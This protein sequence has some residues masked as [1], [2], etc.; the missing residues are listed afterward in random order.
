M[1]KFLISLSVISIAL[2]P[3]LG[4]AADLR[5]KDEVSLAKAEVINEDAYI[6]GGNVTLANDIK[7]DLVVAG[8]NI[9]ISGVVENDLLAAGGNLNI[10]GTIRDDARI[11]GGTVIVSGNVG[12]DI[13]VAGGQIQILPGSTIGGDL[14]VAGG[15]VTIDGTVNG[16][17]Q[18]RGGQLIINDAVAGNVDA[19]ID[20]LK[21]GSHSLINGDLFYRSLE[22]GEIAQGA[23]INGTTKF[24]KFEKLPPQSA[25]NLKAILAS[26]L[27]AKFLVLAG[28]LIFLILLFG[29]TSRAITRQ[30]IASFWKEA[31]RGFVLLVVTPV[32]AIF[33]FV[34]IVGVPLGGLMLL[35]YFASL[36]IAYLFSALILGSMLYKLVW[37]KSEYEANWKTALLGSAVITIVG[38]IPFIGGFVKFIFLLVALGALVKFEY[39][40]RWLNR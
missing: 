40:R 19:K 32:A 24:E 9:V 34:T 20:K 18:M 16:N 6:V 39:E 8:G 30:A 17:I 12:G 36:T 2:A 28:S 7:G 29:S 13:A 25:R 15:V 10:L 27:V 37:R 31:L 33:F 35:L 23:K 1:K 3:A 11:V 21:L 5:A 4:F 38:I 26:F 14:I 22:E